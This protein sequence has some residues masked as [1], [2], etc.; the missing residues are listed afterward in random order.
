VVLLYDCDYDL[1]VLDVEYVIE[2]I[3]LEEGVETTE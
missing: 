1:L 3:V 2:G